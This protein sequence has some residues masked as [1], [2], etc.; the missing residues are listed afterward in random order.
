MLIT[1][2]L[3]LILVVGLI[4][5]SAHFGAMPD[6]KNDKRIQT[7]EN[8]EGKEFH[9]IGKVSMSM[10]MKKGLSLIP[11]MFKGSR[12][13][14]PRNTDKFAD[15]SKIIFE[16][17][18]PKITRVT[19]LGH[20]A[21]MID[22]EGKR[23]L[24]DPMLSKYASPFPGFV[25]RF[26]NA[27]HFSDEDYKNLGEID[28]ILISH[29]HYDH[30]D[31]E[32]IS[33]L[34][35]QTKIF[36][37]P[38]GVRCHLEKWGVESEKIIELDWWED[39]DFMGLKFACTPSQH[40]SGRRPS[41]RNY[42]LWCSWAIIGEK[43]KVFFSGDSGYFP[44][45]KQIGSKYGP[46]DVALLECGQYNELWKEIHM[47]PEQ[48]VT[49]SIDLKAKQFIPIHNRSFNL[50]LHP[51]T[52]PMERV[53]AEAKKESVEVVEIIPGESLEIYF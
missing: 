43:A 37:V 20:S 12:L 38:L 11:K 51:W 48:T 53:L 4:F 50:A 24:L 21:S 42:A 46:F 52:E 18:D 31:F 35:S 14:K 33:N 6:L 49:A 30:L 19:W 32:S 41:R 9:N 47:L 45:F 36:V 34:F 17:P 28:A 23:L 1:L 40:F 44:S 8:F 3:L 13:R 25:K 29:D 27:I 16:K 10:N 5:R 7:S 15:K 26:N 39:S 22:I 2:L